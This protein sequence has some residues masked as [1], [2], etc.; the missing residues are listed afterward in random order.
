MKYKYDDGGIRTEKT[1]N[2]VTTKFVTNGIQVLAQ[3]T[4]DDKIIW[5]IDGNGET[6]GFNHN[7]TQYFYIKNAQSD[8]VGIT[9][10]SGN[11]KVNY[12]YDSWGK[13][14]SIND[15]S[16]CNIGEINPI[17]YRGYYY[18]KEIQLYYLN[19]RYYDP[20]TGRFISADDIL[21]DLNLFRYCGNNSV[22]FAD[23]TGEDA[24]L[25]IDKDAANTLGHMGIAIEKDGK[26]YHFYYGCQP[27]KEAQSLI[28]MGGTKA[29]CWGFEFGENSK[30]HSGINSI[31]IQKSN[32]DPNVKE[33]LYDGTYTDSRYL[34]GNFS[35][36]Y[37][38]IVNNVT[39]GKTTYNATTYNCKH[40]SLEALSK[41]TFNDHDK[42]YKKLLDESKL[43]IAPNRAF[44]HFTTS[45]DG[46]FK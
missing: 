39:L 1:V 25:L 23:Y 43:K 29:E 28:G 3:K 46:G 22:N 11:L 7:G 38:H 6:V 18:D 37:D 15:T 13:L 44:G 14:I 45:H 9:D 20:E 10:A 40:A 8:I 30:D 31:T 32:I 17:R 34:K 26:W 4:G 12:T 16:D 2:D 36:S 41:G 42:E 21:S 35:A 33:K 24:I 19:A 27:G 5:Q